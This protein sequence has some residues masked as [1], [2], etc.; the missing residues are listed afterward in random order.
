[1]GFV[2]TGWAKDVAK[3][4]AKV[5][6]PATPAKA[7][8][9]AAKPEVAAVKPAKP[10]TSD[11]HEGVVTSASKGELHMTDANGKH[12]HTH[13]VGADASVMR[14]GKTVTL[15][16]LKK[17]DHVTVTTKSEGGKTMVVKVD[18]KSKA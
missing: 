10:A 15:G 5:E 18:A 8:A 9:P 1:M 11:T 17:G 4:A 14:D 3:P 7:A 2:A 16:D 6:K 13:K 12:A